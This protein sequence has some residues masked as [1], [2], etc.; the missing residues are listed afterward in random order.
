MTNKENNN[1]RGWWNPQNIF[2]A[3]AEEKKAEK[4]NK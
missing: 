3:M 2:D 4:N 1:R